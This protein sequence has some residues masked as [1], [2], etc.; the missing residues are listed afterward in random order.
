MQAITLD[1]DGLHYQPNYPEPAIRGQETLVRV[2]QAGICETDL[3]L[4]QGYMGFRGVPGHEFVGIALSGRYAGQRVVGEINCNCRDCETCHA[5]RPTHCP[6]RTVLGI[7]H[8]DGAFAD[9]L[10]V[11]E[12]HLHPVPDSVSDDQAVFVEPLAAAFEITQQ[13]PIASSDRVAILG[14][15]RLG[16]LSAQ[17]LAL[18][19]NH[20]TVFGKHGSKLLRFGHQGHT[21]VQISPADLDDLPRGRFDV[22]VDCTGSTS[23]LPMAVHLVRPRGTVVL[24]TTVAE[25]HQLSLAS[26]VI[27][28][29]KLVGSRC[30]PFDLALKALREDRIDVAELITDRF[31]LEQFEPAF[32]RATDANSFK[33][34]F[35]VSG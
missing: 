34:V 13:V 28:E 24:K 22:V 9:R 2:R 19:S 7:D 20:I 6:H 5:G 32:E 35:E 33:V 8:H 26:V 30:G 23:G 15:G 12:H 18:S 31:S 4:A 16:Y 14:D 21:T 29:I 25:P 11:P 17:V 10:A 27:D 1:A 3:Q